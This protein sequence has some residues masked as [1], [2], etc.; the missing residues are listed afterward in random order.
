M[1]DRFLG[2]KLQ[3]CISWSLRILSLSVAGILFLTLFPFRF[4]IPS[5]HSLILIAGM[6][7]TGSS[8]DI[9][10]NV[11]LMF[12]LGFGLAEYFSERGKSRR[13]ILISS[14]F[15]GFLFSYTIETLQIY[16]PG[17]DSGWGDV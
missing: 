11:L 2:T 15:A 14:F 3:P 7:K 13:F 17:R 8:L 10:L 5:G 4:A 9:F 16:V 12:P 6:G 1:P